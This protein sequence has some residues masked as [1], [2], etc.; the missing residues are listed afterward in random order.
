MQLPETNQSDQSGLIR[1]EPLK[2]KKLNPLFQTELTTQLLY[3]GLI[4]C[5]RH[6]SNCKSCK[7]IRVQEYKC[8]PGI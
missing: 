4:R 2:R 1:R 6:F 3:K 7:N 5:I 8:R